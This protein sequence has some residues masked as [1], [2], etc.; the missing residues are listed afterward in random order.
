MET[1]Q[2]IL[3]GAKIIA[4]LTVVGAVASTAN[5]ADPKRG[6]T[7]TPPL[8]RR[9]SIWRRHHGA[10]CATVR[11]AAAARW[12]IQNP[13]LSGDGLES[14]RRRLIGHAELEKRREIPRWS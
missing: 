4:A 6:G 14:F 13:S 10:G 12:A 11:D 7:L 1:K 5:A 2:Y 9:R 8:Q 3:S